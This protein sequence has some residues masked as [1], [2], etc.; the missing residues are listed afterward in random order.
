MRCDRDTQVIVKVAEETSDDVLWRMYRLTKRSA[1]FWCVSVKIVEDYCYVGLALH[2]KLWKKIYFAVSYQNLSC[3]PSPS[4]SN[5]PRE[6]VMHMW[7]VWRPCSPFCWSRFPRA[8]PA[9]P[10]D[11][12]RR[13]PGGRGLSRERVASHSKRRDTTWRNRR[14]GRSARIQRV[15]AQ[16]TR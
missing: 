2:S 3:V 13:R 4:T 6:G 1:H 5:W 15:K 7:R 14:G 12:A 16:E 8:V 11:V 10:P 9:P